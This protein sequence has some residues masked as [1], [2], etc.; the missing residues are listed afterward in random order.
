MITQVHALIVTQHS[1]ACLHLLLLEDLIY[2][3]PGFGSA[4]VSLQ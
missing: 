3:A 2:P 1:Y 4:V